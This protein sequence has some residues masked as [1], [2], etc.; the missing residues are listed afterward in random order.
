MSTG[1]PAASKR[2]DE[3]TSF[4]RSRKSQ[5]PGRKRPLEGSLSMLSPECADGHVRSAIKSIVDICIDAPTDERQQL[6]QPLPS[7]EQGY[8]SDECAKGGE[9]AATLTGYD[10]KE[11]RSGRR[12][13]GDPAHDLRLEWIPGADLTPT[14]LHQSLI[15]SYI[16][17]LE[18][19][20]RGPDRCQ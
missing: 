7:I 11:H 12:S 1:S 14:P 4:G 10:V 3:K 6:Q 20:R 19:L 17:G 8:P 2:L 18:R 9:T 5:T 13:H 16:M 15:Q